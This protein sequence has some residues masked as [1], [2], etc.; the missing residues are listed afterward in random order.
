[1]NKEAHLQALENELAG[2][3]RRGLIE[4]ARQVQQELFR[5]GRPTVVLP[6]ED[7]PSKSESTPTPPATTAQASASASKT[8]PDTKTLSKR[9]KL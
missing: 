1:M 6:A 7:V 5:L 2:Y 9:K 4:R 8:K 3:I